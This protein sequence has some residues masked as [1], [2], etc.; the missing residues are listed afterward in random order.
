MFGDYLGTN[1][2][3]SKAIVAAY[4]KHDTQS[5]Y[6]KDVLR[7][8][9]VNP[10]NYVKKDSPPALIICGGLDPSNVILNCSAMFDKYIQQGGVA[11]YYALSNGTHVRVGTAIEQASA[12]WLSEKLAKTPPPLFPEQ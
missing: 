10:L 12:I 2:A 1:D 4:R 5:P 6:W 7:I 3:D 11:S 8:Q 9:Q